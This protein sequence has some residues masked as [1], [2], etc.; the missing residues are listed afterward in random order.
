MNNIDIVEDLKDSQEQIVKSRQQIVD[1]KAGDR[2]QSIVD[3][4]IDKR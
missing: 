1:R 3:N 2:R 4:K